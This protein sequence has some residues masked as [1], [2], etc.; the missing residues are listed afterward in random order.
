MARKKQETLVLFPEVMEITRK[1][2][3]EKFGILMRAVFSYRFCG[4]EY[5]GDDLAIEVAFRSVASQVDRYTEFCNTQSMNRK[6]NGGTPSATKRTES[7]P[8]ETPVLS[9]SKSTSSSRPNPDLDIRENETE[10]LLETHNCRSGQRAASPQ[11]ATTTTSDLSIPSSLEEVRTYVEDQGLAM[12]SGKFFDYY[13]AKGWMLGSNPVRDWRALVRGWAKR[14]QERPA[15]ATRNPQL[16]PI[17][18]YEGDDLWS[19]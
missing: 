7:Q 9:L 17:P 3:D 6:G 5:Q 18:N 15:T 12:D 11:L 2:S 13:S 16:A 10:S 4:E 1:F 14:E 8:S 19:L